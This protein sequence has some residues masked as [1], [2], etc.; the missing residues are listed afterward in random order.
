MWAWMLFILAVLLVGGIVFFKSRYILCPSN[1]ILVV[2]GKVEQGKSSQCYNGGCA[3]VMPLVQSYAFLSLEP[4]R[5]DIPLK[6]E[7][8]LEKLNF[9]LPSKFTVAISTEPELMENA[10]QRLLGLPN[11]KKEDLARDIIM[12]Q[13][14]LAM[15]DRLHSGETVNEREFVESIQEKVE[16]KLNT[17]GLYL[18][19]LI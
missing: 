14:K 17:V 5:V 13:L 9:R 16:N 12:S 10:A 2:Y 8:V 4:L 19:S 6:Q 18:I 3:F 11:E 1:R 15:D 7:L